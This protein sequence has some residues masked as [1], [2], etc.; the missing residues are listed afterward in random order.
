MAGEPLLIVGGSARAAAQSA[1]R[2]GLVPRTCDFFADADLRLLCETR[3]VER[4]PQGLLRAAAT[5]SPSPWMYTGALENRPALV[6][7]IAARRPLWGNSGEVLRRIRDPFAVERALVKAG[8][9]CP[10]CR[11]GDEDVPRDGS[12][13][14]KRFKSA[15]GKGV[16]AWTAG[17]PSPAERPRSDEAGFYQRRIA[18]RAC[19]AVYIAAQ[20][21]AALVGVTEQLVGSR[22]C[23]AAAFQ[24]CG[25]MG[26]LMEQDVRSQF[27]RIGECLAAEFGLIG[28]FGVDALYD[29]RDVWPVEINPRYPASLEVLE[30][31]LD[32]AVLRWHAEACTNG[33]LPSSMDAEPARYCGKAIL[34]AQ[35]PHLVNAAETHRLLADRR[36]N[37]FALADIPAA[38]TRIGRRHPILTL[39]VSGECPADVRRKLRE[40][41]GQ[42]RRRLHRPAWL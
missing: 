10:E 8:L 15:S 26:P 12:W 41:A 21:R 19:S 11:H 7:R 40:S 5:I 30:R 13:M 17:T 23:G 37:R 18:G 33:R 1:L 3:R 38:G 39:L 29:L 20:G 35:Q 14:F 27:A 28:V 42:W 32:V 6:D 36:S 31:S 34:F 24:Y 4:Y 9:R 22:W 25:S 16:S 2:A